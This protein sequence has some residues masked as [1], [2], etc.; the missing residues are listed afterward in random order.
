[1]LRA[2]IIL[3]DNEVY[4]FNESDYNLRNLSEHTL[5]VLAD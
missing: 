4:T 2:I 1:M 3:N 5:M